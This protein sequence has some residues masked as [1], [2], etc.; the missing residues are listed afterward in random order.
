M[1][2]RTP[3][4]SVGPRIREL[5]EQQGWSLSELSGKAG[6]SRSYLYQ[7]EQ[8]ESRPTERIIQKLA[9]ALGA[10]PSELLGE[11]TEQSEIPKS[12]QEFARQANLQ[13]AE[14]NMLAQIEYRGRRPST[15]EEWKAIFHVIRGLLVE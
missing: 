15:V 6:I 5:R 9:I 3:L 7:I 12:L 13:P 4:K 1:P 14:I 10:M 8:E 11:E 2:E